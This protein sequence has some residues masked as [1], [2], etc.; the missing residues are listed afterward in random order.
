VAALYRGVTARPVFSPPPPS[1]Q[2]RISLS[3]ALDLILVRLVDGERSSYLQTRVH[4]AIAVRL[5][6]L[7]K[8]QMS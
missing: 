4:H 5:R 3:E 2:P 7:F 1:R 8:Y 6:F